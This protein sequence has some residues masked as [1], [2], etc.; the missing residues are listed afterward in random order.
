MALM[1]ALAD[2]T[3]VASDRMESVSAALGEIAEDERSRKG[4]L[5]LLILLVLAVLGVVAWKKS[6]RSS[7]PEPA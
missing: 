6:S 7:E 1:D 2:V 4:L 5:I 3:E